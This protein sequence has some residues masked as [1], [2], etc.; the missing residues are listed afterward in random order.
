VA[1]PIDKSQTIAQIGGAEP[2]P[3]EDHAKGEGMKPRIKGI[4]DARKGV[5]KGTQVFMRGGK[6]DG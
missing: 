1:G 2:R 4:K 5:Q 3:E 6:K